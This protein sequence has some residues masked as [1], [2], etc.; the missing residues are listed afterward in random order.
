[1]KLAHR[2][3]LYGVSVLVHLDIDVDALANDLG[4]KAAGN[5]SG[6]AAIRFGNVKASFNRQDLQ[7]LTAAKS[8]RRRSRSQSPPTARYIDPID[9]GDNLGESPDY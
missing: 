3:V 6:R 9:Q 1:M 4:A 8:A 7:A 2:I 5:A